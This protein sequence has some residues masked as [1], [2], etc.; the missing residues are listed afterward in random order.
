MDEQEAHTNIVKVR[1]HNSILPRD[2]S[3]R[4]EKVW[5]PSFVFSTF[6]WLIDL[7]K[8]NVFAPFSHRFRSRYSTN[9]TRT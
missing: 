5:N 1:S 3:I 7:C 6:T 2:A 4:H 9:P 8:K